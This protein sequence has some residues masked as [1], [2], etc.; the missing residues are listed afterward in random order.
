MSTESAIVYLSFVMC[1]SVYTVLATMM[2]ISV[3]NAEL[4]AQCVKVGLACARETKATSDH[5]L[6]CFTFND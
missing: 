2:K 1:P 4:T 6:Q 5:I 3:T